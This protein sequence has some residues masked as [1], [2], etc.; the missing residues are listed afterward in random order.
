MRATSEATVPIQASGGDFELLFREN[1]SAVVRHAQRVTGNLAEAEELASEAFVKLMRERQQIR[2]RVGWLKKCVLFMALDRLRA[3]ERRDN[4]ERRA[5]PP[6][7]PGNPESDAILQQRQR[8]VRQVLSSLSTQD[9]VLL[10]ARADGASYQEAAELAG[11]RVTSTGAK[12]AR[13]ER[14]FK[15]RYEEMYGDI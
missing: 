2:D 14:R 10:L 3:N 6:N 13:A 8:Q 15:E 11:I 1:Y 4:R 9:A 7:H 12:L 5:A